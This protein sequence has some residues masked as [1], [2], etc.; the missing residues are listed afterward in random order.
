MYQL[1][2]MPFCIEFIVTM[3]NVEKGHLLE[4]T[5]TLGTAIWVLISNSRDILLLFEWKS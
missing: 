2:S 3:Y 4:N 1:N 5:K